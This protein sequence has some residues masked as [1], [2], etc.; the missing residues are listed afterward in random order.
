LVAPDPRWLSDD[1]TGCERFFR[2]TGGGSPETRAIYTSRF[3]LAHAAASTFGCAWPARFKFILDFD[4]DEA[5]TTLQ[6]K[7]EIQHP[8]FPPSFPPG[9]ER[10]AP[11]IGPIRVAHR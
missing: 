11:D 1:I 10:Q 6:S 5:D 7:S 8:K 2:A 9:H 4:L 3:T